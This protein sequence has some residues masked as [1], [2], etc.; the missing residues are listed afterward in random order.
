MENLEQ[1]GD[2]YKVYRKNIS[3]KLIQDGTLKQYWIDIKYILKI[4]NTDI[5]TMYSNEIIFN[6][7]MEKLK[8][9]IKDN[10]LT[11]GTLSSYKSDCENF[12]KFWQEYKSIYFARV[13]ENRLSQKAVMQKS[14]KDSYE[15]LIISYLEKN[16]KSTID[17]VFKYISSKKHTGITGKRYLREVITSRYKGSDIFGYKNPYVWLKNESKISNKIVSNLKYEETNEFNLYNKK[18]ERYEGELKER[19]FLSK[20]R[21]QQIINLVKQRDNYTCVVCEFFFDN[22]IVE[23]H[24]LVPMY[25]KEACIINTD[26]L[27]TLCPTCHALA[28]TLLK[29]DKSYYNKT[30]LIKKLREIISK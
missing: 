24:H 30:K 11:Q 9:Y 6:E 21:N 29:K 1:I 18:L 3:K 15:Q 4:L 5:E 7:Y 23:A 12:Y 28:H 16:G 25:E 10:N 13:I 22:K 14:L 2:R 20:S 26:E 17:E 19:I 8:K 27:I